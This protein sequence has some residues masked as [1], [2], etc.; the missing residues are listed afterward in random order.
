MFQVS[1]PTVKNFSAFILSDYHELPLNDI[2]DWK[3][4]S[5]MLKERYLSTEENPCRHAIT[6]IPLQTN[7]FHEHTLFSHRALYF[8]CLWNSLCRLGSFILFS[9]LCVNC[10]ISLTPYSWIRSKGTFRGIY[11]HSNMIHFTW[12]CMTCGYATTLPST[13]TKFL[14]LPFHKDEP[15]LF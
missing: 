15:L 7:T 1:I 13:M 14:K 9:L 4:F 12:S 11:L 2:L 6:R 3:K 8:N 5:V 10:L